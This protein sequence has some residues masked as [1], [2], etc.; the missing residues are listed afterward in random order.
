LPEVMPRL[1]SGEIPA[2]CHRVRY[3]E[4]V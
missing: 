1:A 2:L 3:P 4:T